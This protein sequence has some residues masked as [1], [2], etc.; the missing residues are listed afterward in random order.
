ML[1]GGPGAKAVQRPG[2]HAVDRR[3]LVAALAGPHPRQSLPGLV[4]GQLPPLA[5]LVGA[6]LG[7]SR[8]DN[9]L[10]VHAPIPPAPAGVSGFESNGHRPVLRFPGDTVDQAGANAPSTIPVSIEGP[11][12]AL[13]AGVVESE[14]GIEPALRSAPADHGRA[15]AL[16]VTSH[17]E[18]GLL[19][20]GRGL[21]AFTARGRG[22]WGWASRAERRNVRRESCPAP[23]AIAGEAEAPSSDGS[24]A[25]LDQTGGGC[26]F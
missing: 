12:H 4:L 25:A 2:A 13:L 10:P 1:P 16:A 17:A 26:H 22:D 8:G 15:A 20:G 7:V 23:A 9:V 19:R 3:E 6:V 14:V 24:A 5:T 11:D 18:P 21:P